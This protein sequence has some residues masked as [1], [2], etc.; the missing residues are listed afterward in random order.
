MKGI[1]CVKVTFK[2]QEITVDAAAGT[3]IM[4]ALIDAGLK[5]DAPCGGRGV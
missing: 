3:T 2:P 4:E 5:I 1:I